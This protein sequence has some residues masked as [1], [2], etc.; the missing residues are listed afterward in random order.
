MT[1]DY[2]LTYYYL[3]ARRSFDVTH[4]QTPNAF[5]LITYPVT[6]KS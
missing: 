2:T 1:E 6:Y 5:S 3:P 4:Q